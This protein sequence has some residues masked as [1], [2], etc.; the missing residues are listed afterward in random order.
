MIFCVK[1]LDISEDKARKITIALEEV[2]KDEVKTEIRYEISE[3]K[4]IFKQDFKEV[5]SKIEKL[6]TKIEKLDGKIENEIAKLEVKIEQTKF[7]MIK[8]FVGLFIALAL[9]IVGLYM[10]K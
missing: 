5:D 2:V 4:S 10:K 9:M 7:D 3:F 1:E 8:W 6:D